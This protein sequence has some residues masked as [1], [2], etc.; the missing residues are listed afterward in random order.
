M[1]STPTVST[2]QQRQATTKAATT[3]TGH[4]LEQKTLYIT[5]IS[6]NSETCSFNYPCSAAVVCRRYIFNF[7]YYEV[8]CNL[9]RLA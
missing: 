2:T 4:F 9:A 5:V 1:T 6:T 7:L 8:V 3:T